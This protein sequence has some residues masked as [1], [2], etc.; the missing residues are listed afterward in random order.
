MITMENQD[1]SS[2]SSIAKIQVLDRIESNDV[3]DI[4]KWYLLDRTKTSLFIYD[5][6]FEQR[7]EVATDD[8]RVLVCAD[9]FESNLVVLKS[10][11]C[12]YRVLNKDLGSVLTCI[13]DV[14]AQTLIQAK[15]KEKQ[16]LITE[17]QTEIKNVIAHINMSGT[18][19]SDSKELIVATKDT[20]MEQSRALKEV[21]GKRIDELNKSVGT[22]VED[23]HAVTQYYAL[24]ATVGITKFSKSKDIVNEKLRELSLYGGLNEKETIVSSGGVASEDKPVYIYQNLKYMDVECIIGYQ[25]GGITVTS[26]ADF[27][28]W[29]AKP[30]NRNRVMPSDKSIIAIKIRKHP[31]ARTWQFGVNPNE[32]YLY[33]RNGENIKAIKTDLRIDGTLL[34]TEND[35]AHNFYTKKI[36]NWGKMDENFVFLSK[37]EYDHLKTLSEQVKPLYLDTLLD[38]YRLRLD[39]LIAVAAYG[40]HKMNLLGDMQ[41]DAARTLITNNGIE[42]SDFLSQTL[43][44]KII[45]DHNKSILE[46]KANIQT[47]TACIKNNFANPHLEFPIPKYD[48]LGVFNTTLSEIGF[49]AED[50]TQHLMQISHDDYKSG[51]DALKAKYDSLGLYFPNN[52]KGTHSAISNNPYKIIS[53]LQK[54]QLTD[55]SNYFFDDIKALNWERYKRQNDLAILVQGLFDRGTFFGHTKVSLFKE[56]F[57][58]KIKLVY[59]LDKGLFDGDMPDFKAYL[60]NNRLNSKAGDIF[61]GQ[62]AFWDDMQRDKDKYQ[63]GYNWIDMPKYLKAHSI[64][65]KRDGSTV[66]KFKWQTEHSYWSRAKKTPM[67][68]NAY[69]C[70]IREL[71]NVSSYAPDDCAVFT[72]DPRCRDRYPEWGRLMMAAETY[73]QNNGDLD[74]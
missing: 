32:T 33:I 8:D 38:A 11:N 30:V 35:L 17:A 65:K 23:L 31:D 57:D 21:Y 6:R 61:Y 49:V 28:E 45:E 64:V 46:T 55:E 54:Y 19:S 2:K 3:V 41:R 53:D 43:S 16:D 25:T 69:E 36:G 20:L 27:N 50:G 56:G 37:N 58:D 62:K 40:E 39:Y 44:E 70:D 74:E 67:R 51:I 68:N 66:V 5:R 59:D 71:I 24:P 10:N 34:A 14:E 15:G 4:G 63:A 72:K 18:Q 22:Y 7:N 9:Y 12:S 1:N 13:T 60:E 26:T 47:I 73:H 52:G 42:K 48:W 29:L